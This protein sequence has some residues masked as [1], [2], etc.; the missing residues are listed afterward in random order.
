MRRIKKIFVVTMIISIIS[1]IFTACGETKNTSTES[2]DKKDIVK[3]WTFPVEKDYKENFKKIKDDFENKNKNI[4][5]EA[6]ELSWQ[7]GIKKFDTAINA[8]SPPD[9]MFVIPSAKYVQTGLAV[10]V[11]DYIDKDILKDYYS[12]ALSYMKVN[13]KLYG[14]PL[15]M[16]LHTIG[17][18]KKLL[19][20]SGINWNKIQK[21]GWTW[22]EFKALAKKGTK[23]NAEGKQ[24]YGFVFH[25]A[26]G[27]SMSSE[28]LEHM[29]ANNG[30]VDA[31]NEEN[32]Y[33]Y[34]DEKFL[35]TLK[36]IR[37]LIDEGIMPKE[38]NQIT[39]QKRMEY[40]YSHQAMIIGKAMPYY[41]ITIGDNNTKVREGKAPK[42]QKEVDFVL[43]PEP[44]NKG[45]KSISPGGVDGYTMYKQKN[46]KGNVS[47]K[48]HLKNTAEVL[49]ALTSGKAGESAEI[50]CLPQVT[51]SGD[52]MWKDK[53]TMKP[54]NKLVVD[55]LFKNV[56]SPV[57]ADPQI[58]KKATKIKDEVIIPKYSALLG[59]D[60]TSEDMYKAVKDKA[61]ELF[62]EK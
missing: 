27:A 8:G 21:E 48:E 3:V 6:E 18:N 13:N 15:Y 62:G 2:E 32:K 11:E 58:A 38:S 35:Q 47:Q 44:H 43:L 29:L 25:G 56:P 49:V 54:E 19:E 1:L 55:T 50:L 20:E 37:S 12:N 34:S 46:Y 23:K 16:K 24:Q 9:L 36:F 42:G 14:L 53:Y 33:T 5:I 10:N 40:L 39:P 60:I 59:G 31:V 41:E 22:D 7:E 52:A 28:L 57:Q 4:K 61:K 45:Q 51:K 30:L 26:G 17:G